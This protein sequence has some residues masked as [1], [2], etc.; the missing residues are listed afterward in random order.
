MNIDSAILKNLY[1]V[2]SGHLGHRHAN[3]CPGA[4]NGLEARDPECAACLALVAAEAVPGVLWKPF[5]QE[6]QS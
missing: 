2:A 6:P 5:N 4:I 1:A 3:S